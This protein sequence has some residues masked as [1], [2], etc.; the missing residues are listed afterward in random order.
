MV[1]RASKVVFEYSP[2]DSALLILCPSRLLSRALIRHH[3]TSSRNPAPRSQAATTDRVLLLLLTLGV[4][5][6]VLVS[7]FLFGLS[8]TVAAV[9]TLV[10]GVI[11][12]AAAAIALIVFLVRKKDTLRSDTATMLA[13]LSRAD[14]QYHE[15]MKKTFDAFDEAGAGRMSDANFSECISYMYPKIRSTP[16]FRRLYLAELRPIMSDGDDGELFLGI[17]GFD[18]ALGLVQNLVKADA[19]AHTGQHVRL[20]DKGVHKGKITLKRRFFWQRHQNLKV[21]P[22]TLGE[23]SET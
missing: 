18:A 19:N 4:Y 21:K 12:T 10:C 9:V 11:F 3:T 17:D 16:E 1:D 23:D 15:L 5:P 7:M 2:L 14:P 22:H 6:V 20:D 13:A 8:K